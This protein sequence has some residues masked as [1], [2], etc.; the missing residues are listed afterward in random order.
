[1]LHGKP[2]SQQTTD[3][4]GVLQD[5]FGLDQIATPGSESNHDS[6]SGI[7]SDIASYN[8][9]PTA[10]TTFKGS[11]HSDRHS[12]DSCKSKTVSFASSTDS[13]SS[14]YYVQMHTKQR[15]RHHPPSP[16]VSK[17]ER[18]THLYKNTVYDPRYIES[19]MDAM[20][21]KMKYMDLQ[22]T[23][24]L[25]W[26][27]KGKY[28]YVRP[29]PFELLTDDIV[30]R[31][32]SNLPTD[33]LCRSSRVCLRWY[34]LIWEHPLLWTSIVINND[35]VNIDKALKYLMRRLSYNTPKVCVILERMNLN[36]CHQL[37]DKGLRVI[38]R[39]C[40]ELRYLELKGCFNVTNVALFDVVSS[41]VNL[42][43]LDV[44]GCPLVTC[45]SLTDKLLSEST[46]HNQHQIYLRYLDMSDCAALEDVGLGVITSH[47]SQLQ[48]LY[49]RRCMRITDTGIRHI[50]HNCL[51]LREFSVSDCKRVTDLGLWELSKLGDHLR[52]LSVAKCD[53]VSDV[54]VM[55][56]AKHCA[57][58]RYLNVRG[59]E[60]VSDESL[61]YISCNC[62]RLRS[63]DVGKCDITDEGLQL[64]AEN[65]PQLRKLSVKSCEGITD[66]G[67]AIVAYHCRGLAQ[68]NI[69]DCDLS[70][71]TYRTVKKYCR[72]CIIEH[73]N[74]AF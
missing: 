9:P 58:L 46:S 66:K 14:N 47:C 50:A 48:F 29:S 11:A 65:C 68:L 60:A 42:E 20:K 8:Y 72:G 17:S 56:V 36:G 61:E 24:K 23:D 44:T 32:L 43:H 74:P 67:I 7:A 35:S 51:Y 28:P 18:A 55:Y 4:N 71:E 5:L 10:M 52:Y 3:W 39:R 33:H 22:D 69:Q 40:P 41:C 38:A 53:K 13:K 54:G 31:I 34:R 57:K 49:L 27:A 37:T 25:M 63:L 26:T 1:M 12:S 70:V 21:S 73:T 45:I 19:Q 64:L 15:V 2:T 30:L 16:V 62:P 6:S 59:C